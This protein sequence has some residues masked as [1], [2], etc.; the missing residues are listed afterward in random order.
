MI[1]RS[2]AYRAKFRKGQGPGPKIQVLSPALA[3]PHPRNRGG[4][5]IRTKQLGNSICND[6]HDPVEAAG[7]AVAVEAHAV[8][9]N[10]IW[11]TFQEHIEQQVKG[12]DPDMAPRVNGVVAVIVTVSHGHNQ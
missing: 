6:G 1:K 12:K 10:P 5:P 11:G 4:D 7:S 3:V 2:I 8:K 9:R